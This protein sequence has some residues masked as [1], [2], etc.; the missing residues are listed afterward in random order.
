MSAS[1]HRATVYVVDDDPTVRILLQATLEQKNIQ[2]EAYDCAEKFLLAYQPDMPGCLLLDVLMPG[3]SGLELQQLLAGQGSEIPIIF[4]SG[5]SEVGIAV[6][7][8]KAGAVDF[9]EK[10][11]QPNRVLDCVESAMKL[12]VERRHRRSRIA[13][14]ELRK[15]LL[16]RR[17]EEVM[18]WIVKDKSSKQ[19]AR[20]LGISSRTVE[21][22]RSRVM[23][24]M[25]ARS[26][27]DL[28]EMLMSESL[29]SPTTYNYV[30]LHTQTYD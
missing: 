16:T 3:M 6:D 2:V 5:A 28:A 29:D 10:P 18:G 7:A 23:E 19:I 26:L 25:Q 4:L 20:L 22:H 30:S 27:I 24:K 13:E 17:E 11:V 9:I 14:I 21:T 12:D 15:Q 1:T 8:L